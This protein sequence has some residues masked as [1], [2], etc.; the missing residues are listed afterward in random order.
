MIQ[1]ST[2]NVM[3]RWN[4]IIMPTTYE[5]EYDS[6]PNI[7][8]EEALNHYYDPIQRVFRLFCQFII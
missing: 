4:I 2:L 3:M 7:E 6:R 8:C 1:V 5:F